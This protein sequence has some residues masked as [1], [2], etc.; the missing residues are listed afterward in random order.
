MGAFHVLCHVKTAGLFRQ[1]D[2]GLDSVAIEQ[3]EE[4]GGFVL[5][6]F[7][8]CSLE[9]RPVR[10]VSGIPDMVGW[11]RPKVEGWFRISLSI[12]SVANLLLIRGPFDKLLRI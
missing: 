4:F 7:S 1:L 12:I 9:E 2:L 6:F 10:T 5:E 8:T 11:Y 3:K